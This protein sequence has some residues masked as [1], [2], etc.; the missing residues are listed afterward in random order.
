M[1]L[2]V[3]IYFWSY[4]VTLWILGACFELQTT[5]GDSCHL[6]DHRPNQVANLLLISDLSFKKSQFS[7]RPLSRW[8]SHSPVP[9]RRNAHR[10]AI[11]L[12][13]RRETG[14]GLQRKCVCLS[15]NAFLTTIMSYTC[16]A[17]LCTETHCC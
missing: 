15:N 4:F 6:I 16:T 7:R 14:G 1:F 10:K 17:L 8:R 3:Y 5:A 13:C 2:F 12:R 9:T 11:S